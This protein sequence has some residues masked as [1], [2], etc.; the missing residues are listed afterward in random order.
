MPPHIS[1]SGPPRKPLQ[2]RSL[3]IP[4]GKDRWSSVS[5][6]SGLRQH[7]ELTIPS[8]WLIL[9]LF[10]K[11]E[12]IPTGS[13]GVDNPLL[14]LTSPEMEALREPIRLH[15]KS[16]GQPGELTLN[17]NP[18]QSVAQQNPIPTPD[19]ESSPFLKGWLNRF[20][21]AQA[22][23]SSKNQLDWEASNP[24]AKQV[25]PGDLLLPGDLGCPQTLSGPLIA[26]ADWAA[27]EIHRDLW[28]AFQDTPP[29]RE[30]FDRAALNWFFE[31]RL[32]RNPMFIELT[33]QQKKQLR[34]GAEMVRHQPGEVIFEENDLSEALF[35]IKQGQ[36]RVVKGETNLLALGDVLDWSLLISG[37]APLSQ[38]SA[39]PTWKAVGERI[40]WNLSDEDP[41][42]PALA[43]DG[44][45]QEWL[46]RVNDFLK[47][48][49]ADPTKGILP[50]WPEHSHPPE[51]LVPSTTSA[52]VWGLRE[53]TAFGRLWLETVLGKAARALK[54]RPTQGTILSVMSEGELM[55]EMGVL[56]DQPR[57]ATCVALGAPR[58][59][60]DTGPVELIRIPGDL[61]TE[62]LAD[63]PAV[64]QK[65]VDQ[66]ARRHRNDKALLAT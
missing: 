30:A 21:G 6:L 45:R 35:L 34:E 2:L 53:R 51:G 28:V 63:A 64:C 41:T 56:A 54:P 37:L 23:K 24:E 46:H 9:R 27:L 49:F 5:L 8:G 52:S 66:V 50:T 14:F 29:F 61:F 44:E 57:S 32:S 62:I 38:E 4:L 18:G 58:T 7:L 55:G 65:V 15:R 17:L 33:A 36:V 11:G 20:L 31:D 26:T 16:Q 3:D 59:Q 47:Q 13:T 43:P 42:D 39:P 19:G 12:T 60:G 25:D 1:F 48:P 40:A 10:R 22:G